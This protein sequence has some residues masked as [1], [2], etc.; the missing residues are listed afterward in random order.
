MVQEEGRTTIECRATDARVHLEI[1]IP[2]GFGAEVESESG[3]IA[4]SGML[5]SARLKTNTGG[6]NVTA[7]WKA[8]RLEARATQPPASIRLPEGDLLVAAPLSEGVD[9][10]VTDTKSDYK[11]SYGRIEVQ[12]TA[13]S[14]MIFDNMAVPLDSLV[15]M[16]WQAPSILEGILRGDPIEKRPSNAP[17]LRDAEGLGPVRFSSDVRLVNL[18]VSVTD[19]NGTPLTDLDDSSF[20]VVEDGVP[21]DLTSVTSGDAPFNLAVLLDMSASTIEDRAGMKLIARRFVAAARPEDNIAVYVLGNELFTVASLLSSD[22]EKLAQQVDTLPPMAG[23]SPL[24]DAIVLAYNEE[25]RQ[26]VGQRNA[27]LIV[28]D[29]VDNQLAALLSTPPSG[30]QRKGKRWVAYRELI[31]HSVADNQ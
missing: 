29:G 4:V 2:Y 16:P 25:L 21:Q 31:V 1:N 20:E 18:F 22:H 17:S 13:P 24:Y 19:E 10:T 7:P 5:I 23:G 6:I 30:K 28:S 14:R 27:L 12:A 8:L 15:K 26:R 11:N 3:D 9:F